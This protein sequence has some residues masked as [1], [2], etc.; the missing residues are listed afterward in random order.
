MQITRIL[1]ALC[2]LLA[3]GAAVSAPYINEDL[4]LSFAAGKDIAHGLAVSPDHWSFTAPGIVWIN[5]AWLSHLVLYLSYAEFGPAGPVALKI[6]LLLGCMALVFFRCVRLGA[7]I[8]GSLFAVMLGTL[9]S[10]P[11]L[12]IRPEN[13]G[14]F[15]FVLFTVLLMDRNLGRTTRR[16]GIPLVLV[17]WSNC[18]GSFM[19]GLGLLAAD[20][21]LVMLRR[22]FRF[23]WGTIREMTSSD[24][25]EAW[26]LAL[27]S[28]AGVAVLNPYGTDN[29]LMPFKQVGTSVVTSHSADW[30][31]LLSFQLAERSGFAAVAGYSYVSFLGIFVI[32]LFGLLWVEVKAGEGRRSP[33]PRFATDLIMEVLIVV[34]TAALAFRF[35]RLGLFAGFSLAP[36]SALVFQ[37]LFEGL[38][39][40][41]VNPVPVKACRTIVVGAATVLTVAMGLLFY[42]VAFVPYWPG[43][44]VRSPRPVLRELM[45]FDTYSPQL[46]AFMKNNKLVDRV[47]AGWELSSFLMSELPEIRQ[48]MDCRDQSLYPPKVVEDY[49]T[50]LGIMRQEGASPFTLLDKYQVS[51][52]VLATTP[53]DFDLAMKLL[54][55]RKWACVYAD[56]WALVLVRPDSEEFRNVV[57]SDLEGLWFPD[58]D[59]KVL[60][61]SFLSYF[62]R[63][64]MSPD[65][66][67]ALKRLAVRDPRPNYYSLICLGLERG[68]TC[69]KPETVKYLISEALRLS[70]ID[71]QEPNRGGQALESLVRIFEILEEN[72]MKCGNA[73]VASEFRRRKQSSQAAYDGLRNKYTGKIY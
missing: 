38:S 69:F 45:S 31:P 26:I 18:H 6:V 68:A 17:A 50:I 47:F 63:G 34:G 66:V 15:F 9:A 21:A 28:L 36:L 4:F 72:A 51:T 49:F 8:G 12:G 24:V 73:A 5:Q 62:L 20:A 1:L 44:P 27:A 39:A 46:P 65:L 64:S 37:R 19:L 55:T 11:F 16:L 42:R 71:P 67:E 60:S 33:S 43:N 48:F 25:A 70:K 54:A 13:F 53:I 2:V 30:L 57:N 52:V 29:L 22:M 7:S 41:S 61:Q 40:P 14:V 59:T 35:G 3:A 32:S 23:S 10:G 56:P 58:S